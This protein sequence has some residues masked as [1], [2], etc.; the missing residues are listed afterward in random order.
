MT[1]R[2]VP[3]IF[4]ALASLFLAG[5]QSS[6]AD[7]WA[8]GKEETYIAQAG[9]QDVYRYLVE[10]ARTQAYPGELAG[11]VQSDLY[12]NIE[13]AFITLLRETPT[14]HCAYIIAVKATAPEVT[15]IILRISH[16]VDYNMVHRWLYYA[17][18]STNAAAG[19]REWD[20]HTNRPR[21]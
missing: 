17:P 15:K 19:T 18:W 12:A 16:P 3:D 9:Y 5:C 14:V 21:L 20:P 4:I 10:K 6:T 13:Q 8:R 2:S 7:L 11:H 1:L